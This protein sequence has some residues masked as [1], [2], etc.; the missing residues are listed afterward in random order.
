M[1]KLLIK[2]RLQGAVSSL[3]GNGK[4]KTSSKG[5]TV[6]LGIV[7]LYLFACVIFLSFTMAL[8]LGAVLVSNGA[9]WLYFAI[10]T[11][12]S[13]SVL[14]FLSIFE[15]KSELFDCKDNELLLSMP[16]PETALVI[17]RTA[18]VL[19]FNYLVEALVMIP[20]VI[21]YA[22]ISHDALGVIGSLVISAVLPLLATALASGVGYLVALVSK[23]L[24]KSSLLSVALSL[25][26]LALYF[27]GY[28]ALISGLDTFLLEFDPSSLGGNLKILEFIGNASLLKPLPL[29]VCLVVAVL[30]SLLAYLL[31]SK[32]YIRLATDNRGAKKIRYKE[33]EYSDRSALSALVR[34]EL[35]KFVSSSTYMLNSGIGLV[36][37]IALSVVALVNK[38]NILSFSA[39]LFGSKDGVAPIMIA[40]LALLSSMNMMSASALSLEGKNL[41]ILK[42][43]PVSD[44]TVLLSK[45]LPQIIISVPAALVSSIL[46]IIATEAPIYYWAFYILVPVFA[47]AFFAFLGLIFNV[48]FPRFDFESEAQPVKQSVAVFL[49]M[50]TQTLVSI[51]VSILASVLSLA[52]LGLISAF[53]TLAIFALLSVI[54]ALLL[55]FPCRKRY[56]KL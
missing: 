40:A 28:S 8:T 55:F 46:M 21:V 54:C 9:S 2:N 44:N 18:V 26:F 25:G 49:T 41:W 33:R 23:R 48:I 51:A 13:L 22:V 16:I 35:S 24:R 56:A 50:T 36:F 1:I 38:N 20:A 34:K 27:W 11:L 45:A 15:T 52:G 17:S 43:T 37:S 53:I 6:L 14:F 4:G 42:T 3:L 47:N 5:R 10:F 39:E 7:Y 29:F 19:L 12:A 32:N 30:L 31:I